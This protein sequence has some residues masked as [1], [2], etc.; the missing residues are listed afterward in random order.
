MSF[1]IADELIPYG[2]DQAIG[3]GWTAA[4]GFK[5]LGVTWHWTATNDL[6]LC[7]RT[8]GG[9]NAE[10]RG[11]AS[12]HFG[13]GR[14]FAEGVARYVS[15]E[16][17]SWHAG[18]NQTLMWNGEPLTNGALKGT[19][20]TI[21]VE[22][23]N[24]GFARPGV[25]A[26]PDWLDAAEPNGTHVMKVQPWTDEQV[27]MMIGVG[28]EIVK[29]WPNIEP[30]HHHGHHDLCANY[31]QDVAAFPFALVLRGIYGN[32]EIPDVWTPFWLPAGRQRALI[33]LG[34]DLGP[35]G[36]DGDWGHLSDVA[37]RRFQRDAGI[38][39]NGLWTTFVC[40]AVYD[41]FF[42]RNALTQF[43][44]LTP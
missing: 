40:W 33:A 8:L 19:R 38:T 35:S 32:D 23:V 39:Q 37:L 27:E 21:G 17:R 31:K 41:A 14:T 29:R 24:I 36:A 13:I 10:R 44:T 22:T 12:A 43:A 28:R 16:D 34:Y 18:I 11:E 5:P 20:T 9:A 42:K 3:R 26:R 25:P 30:R 4:T 2:A 15:I 1:R 6:A 7:T